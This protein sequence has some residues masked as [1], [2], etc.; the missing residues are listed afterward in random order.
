MLKRENRLLYNTKKRNNRV[1]LV[2]SYSKA[3]PDIHTIL[4]KISE[5]MKNVF[6][7]LPITSCKRN[8]NI[9]DILVHHKHSVQ[10]YHR[11]KG[12]KRCG[13]DCA[14]WKHLIESSKFQD[15]EGQI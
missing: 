6:K 2:L 9:K 14:L 13:T 1:P 3:L 10:F 8:K 15:N 4:R 11:E 12:C 5:R 7:E